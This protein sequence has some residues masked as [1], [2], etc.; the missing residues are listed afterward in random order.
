MTPE[1]LF[2]QLLELGEEWRVS[3]CEFDANERVVCLW[4]EE[5]PHFWVVESARQKQ[6]IERYDHTPELEWRHLNVFTHQCVLRCR[7]GP[8]KARGVP[9]RSGRGS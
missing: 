8:R 2:H 9:R 3:R 4:V 5:V 6:R 7:L 1:A